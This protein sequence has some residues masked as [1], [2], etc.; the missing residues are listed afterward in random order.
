MLQHQLDVERGVEKADAATVAT[1]EDPAWRAWP[2]TVSTVGSLYSMALD[3][4]RWI[5]KSI[6]KPTYPLNPK[7]P[8]EDQ[9]NSTKTFR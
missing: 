4:G 2:E 8:Y 1:A 6:P 7:Q 3:F 9:L 5:Q